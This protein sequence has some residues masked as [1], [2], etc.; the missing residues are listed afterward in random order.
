MT[1]LRHWHR[2]RRDPQALQKLLAEPP[3]PG[4]ADIPL[5]VR[6]GWGGAWG[7]LAQAIVFVVML[8]GY[9]LLIGIGLDL[10][11]VFFFAAHL[12]LLLAHSVPDFTTLNLALNVSAEGV[13][14]R[15]VHRSYVIP[16]WEASA[17]YAAPDL[18]R[19]K[20]IGRSERIT[21]ETASL[22]PDVRES[23]AQAL[24]ARALE[25]QIPFDEWPKRGQLLARFVPGAARAGGV[26]VFMLGFIFFL[27]DGTLGMRC[28]ANSA[29]LQQTFGTPTHHGYVV[30]RV[31]AGAQSAGIR[32]GD[33][34]IEMDGVP[35]TSGQ[36]F[37]HLFDKSHKASWDF[38]VLRQGEPE[39]LTF[40]V[41]GGRGRD[42]PEDPSDPF[43]YYL[44]GRW[45][46]A[47][48]PDS[49]MRDYSRV[50]ELE[51]RFDLAYLYRGPLYE[52]RGNRVAAG[53]DYL[54]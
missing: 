14:I 11:L 48:D 3:P 19:M 31:S 9:H 18:L 22:G 38:V 12:L 35:V 8:G 30:L 28:S 29:F 10:F 16:W 49:A 40:H 39:P 21:V 15:K 42:F 51:P 20:V 1:V 41:K 7:Y 52:A 6:F 46:A 43:F 34:V 37:Q 44:R 26:I 53:R 27:P 23:M 25:H 50:I 24:R 33:L 4:A 2:A 32:R 54:K 47:D 17:V 13:R 36:Q 5:E 45:D